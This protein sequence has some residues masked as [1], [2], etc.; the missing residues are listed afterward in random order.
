MDAQFGHLDGVIRTRAGY[1]GGT[2][3]DPTY[4]DLGDH[5]EAVQVDYDPERI[6]YADLVAVFWDSHTCTSQ[7]ASRQYE[8][9]LFYSNAEEER[10]ALESK[11]QREAEAGAD[12]LTRVEPLT[13]FYRAEDYHQ[14]YYL[15]SE[16]LL[17]D[18][19]LSIYP[20]L[21]AFADSTAT[22]RVNAYLAGY[23][24]LAQL[25]AEAGALGLAGAPLERLRDL[26]RHR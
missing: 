5:S 3:A 23:G 7:S 18:Y 13:A 17:R 1:A 10:I 22:A 15:R 9:I 4:Y 14:K 26:V 8:N 20:D 2:T 11:A 12:V 16:W 21:Q 24:T 25:D 19:Y 6:S